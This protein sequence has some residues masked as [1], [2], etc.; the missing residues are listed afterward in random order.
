MLQFRNKLNYVKSVRI[1]VYSVP[2]FPVGL[3]TKKYR[4]S[5]RIQS[6]WEKM[7]TR[8]TPNK[9]TFLAVL[10]LQTNLISET[11]RLLFK[12]QYICDNFHITI[13]CKCI[14][15]TDVTFIYCFICKTISGNTLSEISPSSGKCYMPCMS[16][17]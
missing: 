15:K 8:I 14:L 7:R 3:N 9:Y 17:F 4:G 12:S 1:L 2:H 10:K 13:I 6:E 5:L 16:L 11:A